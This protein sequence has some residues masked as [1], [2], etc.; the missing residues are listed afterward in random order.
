MNLSQLHSSGNGVSAFPLFKASGMIAALRIAAHHQLKK[1]I[2]EVPA[3]L[4][5]VQGRVVFEN[6]K[7]ESHIL[8]PGEFVRIEPEVEHWVDGIEDSQLILMK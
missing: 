1:H 7:G 6:E 3:L 2:T 5:C 8:H 4:L